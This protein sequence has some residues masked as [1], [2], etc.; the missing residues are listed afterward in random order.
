MNAFTKIALTILVTLSAFTALTAHA[1][2]L[3]QA[4]TAPAPLSEEAQFEWIEKSSNGRAWGE[5][6]KWVRRAHSVRALIAVPKGYPRSRAFVW[7]WGSPEVGLLTLAYV[8]GETDHPTWGEAAR[9]AKHLLNGEGGSQTLA[10]W[11]A[12]EAPAEAFR[13]CL[14]FQIRFET[15]K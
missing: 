3:I 5:H 2:I 9:R 11:C 13:E 4:P 6:G 1:D 12:T 15:T 14:A 10:R 8:Y 7:Q